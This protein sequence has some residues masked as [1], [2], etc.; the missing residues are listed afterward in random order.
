M[1]TNSPHRL[2]EPFSWTIV[3]LGAAACVTSAYL[4]IRTPTPEL[5]LRFL[6]L[7]ALV[8][9][10]T[11]RLSVKIPRVKGE[12]TISDSLIFLVILL[13]GGD[14]AVLLAAA[15]ALSSSLRFSRRMLTILFNAGMMAC[16]TFL[17]VWTLRLYFGPIEGVAQLDFS[18]AFLGMVVVMALVQYVANAGIA[19]VRSALKMNQSVLYTWSNGY[20][21]TSVTYF[22]GASGAAIIAK[23]MGMVGSYA[24]LVALPIVGIV[25]VTYRTYLQNVE[26]SQREAEQAQRHV[27][28]LNHHIAEQERISQALKESEE[29]F[30]S[31]FDHAAGMALVETDG[32]WFKVNRSLCHI[33]GYTEEE[34]LAT[35]LAEV[36]HPE[37]FGIKQSRLGALLAGETSTTQLE[38]RFMHKLGHEVWVLTSVSLVRSLQR[39]PSHFI[40]QVQDITEQKRAQEQVHFAAFHDALTGLPNRTLLQARLH[41]AF[42]R[43]KRNRIY[44]FAVLFIDLDRFKVINDSLGHPCGDQLL[45]DISRRLERCVRSVDTVARLGGD[46]FA[47]LLD[48]IEGEYSPTIVA[49]RIGRLLALPFNLD[50]HEVYTSAS[51]GINFSSR[52]YERPDDILRDADTAMYRA[53]SNGK[54]RHEVFDKEMHTRAMELLRLE[55]DLR[56]AVER[57][58]IR[59]YYQP[60]VS[61]SDGRLVGFEA[62][63]RWQHPTRGLV[64]PSDFIALAEETGLI[65]ALGSDILREACRDAQTWQQNGAPLTISVN[66]SAKQLQLPNFVEQV[67]QILRETHLPPGCL[68][69]EITESVVMENAEAA[70]RML[71][72]LK[73]LGIHLSID[74]FGTGYSSLSYLHRFPFSNVKIDRSFISGVTGDAESAKIVKTIIALATELHMNVTAEGV[75]TPKQKMQLADLG[76]QY[77]QGTLASE[78]LEA[79]V[80]AELLAGDRLQFPD[81]RVVGAR[82][83]SS[84]EGQIDS[85]YFN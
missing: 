11:S 17:T 41:H 82:S 37:D 33:L 22:A 3:A 8:I 50:G 57:G 39:E 79:A 68:R 2:M 73:A 59:P 18:P 7:A 43:A 52:D 23:L 77:F 15:E 44:Q 38:N 54:A 78:P 47:I 53:K 74:D 85:V 12:I 66:L 83:G 69:L 75:E 6:L 28:Q 20:L 24:L 58:E 81:C 4:H 71:T 21:W 10:V 34:L 61:L 29:H 51:I 84:P 48:G 76:C 35:S 55:S 45:V 64:L 63:A 13:Y 60:I 27:E 16:A 70:G 40:F 72:R 32:R 14:I 65:L 49:E 1:N 67:E 36:I 31:A 80:V 5:D 56:R 62:L 26:T 46:E 19:A 30:R 42:E 25:Y 9:G